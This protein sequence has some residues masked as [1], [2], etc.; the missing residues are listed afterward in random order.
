MTRPTGA[1]RPTLYLAGPLFTQAER[2]WNAGLAAALETLGHRVLLPQRLADESIEPGQPLP[3]A[4][5]FGLLVDR[6]RETDVIVA[7]LD[8]ADADSGTSFECGVAWA[9]GRPVVGLRTDL[10]RGGDHAD[11][12]VNLMLAHGCATLVK[13]GADPDLVDTAGLAQRVSAAISL[14]PV[15]PAPALGAGPPRKKDADAGH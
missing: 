2:R 15:A 3:T 9:W 7:V 12:D 13:L 8:G 4:E 14:L 5:I 1:A 10:R 6:I 11:R